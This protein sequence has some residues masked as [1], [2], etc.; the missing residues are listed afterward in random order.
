MSAHPEV[1]VLVCGGREYGDQQ[2]VSSVLDDVWFGLAPDQTMTIVHGAARGADTLAHR[3]AQARQVRVRMFP[4]RWA[5]YGKSAGFKRNEQMAS[6]LD[7]QARG[8]ASVRCYAFPGGRGTSHM[9]AISRRHGI[10][11]RQF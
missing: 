9:V 8:G 2:H 11:T 4:A 1:V 6:F 5:E 3:W 10:S 7:E